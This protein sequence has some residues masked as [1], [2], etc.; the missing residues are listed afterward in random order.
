M[1]AHSSS[2]APLHST[3]CVGVLN[4]C[5]GQQDTC[6]PSALLLA[7]NP[8]W[9]GS[10]TP[11]KISRQNKAPYFLALKCHHNRF[12][13][14]CCDREKKILPSDHHY[15]HPRGCQMKIQ[16]INAGEAEITELPYLAG[17]PWKYWNPWK[18]T[19]LKPHPLTPLPQ[20]PQNCQSVR[21]EK[22]CRDAFVYHQELFP[23]HDIVCD[24]LHIKKEILWYFHYS[25]CKKPSTIVL[26]CIPV[27]GENGNDVIG[28]C[29]NAV[30][31]KGI[32]D[33]H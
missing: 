24:F 26:L 8:R 13:I 9:T 2:P 10:F 1:D 11:G 23:F 31:L 5:P 20:A 3:G 16:A 22:Q 7:G 30:R 4:K 17:M 21:L 14:L 6:S 12:Y 33:Y 29:E 18:V 19:S 25:M 32:T 27:M 15:P 28:G